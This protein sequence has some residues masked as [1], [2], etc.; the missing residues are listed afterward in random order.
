MQEILD[1]APARRR[2][3]QAVVQLRR[4]LVRLPDVD[5]VFVEIGRSPGSD[6]ALDLLE[7][8]ERGEIRVDRDLDTGVWGLF[9][10]GDGA[11]A[12]LAA[13]KYLTHQV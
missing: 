3:G 4:K 2:L 1:E 13:F 12:T 9:A 8:N 7:T 11:R 5:G 10:A 6:F